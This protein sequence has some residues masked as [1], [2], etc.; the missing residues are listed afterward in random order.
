[1]EVDALARD[2]GDLINYEREVTGQAR[3]HKDAWKNLQVGDFVRLYNDDE[4]PADVIVL[5]TADNDGACYVETKNLDG[6]TNLK[7]RQA[8]RCGRTLKHARDCE[9][10][11]FSIESEPPQANLYKYNAAIKWEQNFPGVGPKEMSEPI[12]IDNLLLRGCNLRNTEWVLGVVVFTGHD[13]KIMMNAGATPS[14]RPRI[15]RELNFNVLLNFGILFVICL[16]SAI[17]NGV[18]WGKLDASIA[19]FDYGAIGGTPAMTGF[20][21]FFAALIVF[22]NLIPILYTFPSKSYAR[23]KLYSYTA[24]YK[25]ITNQLITPASQNR[26]IFLTMLAKSNISFPTRPALLLKT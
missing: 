25:C 24:T 17:V 8:L 2:K 15:A 3:F 1:M 5:A 11:Q 4:L 20:I 6:E 22:Q 16:L 9:R 12:T 13:T 19:W 23:F 26:G 7:V 10:A 18:S 21:T 14:K